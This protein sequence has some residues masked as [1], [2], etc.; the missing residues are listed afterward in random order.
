MTATNPTRTSTRTKS[1]FRCWCFPPTRLC[2]SAAKRTCDASASLTTFLKLS[3]LAVTLGFVFLLVFD[4]SEAASKDHPLRFKAGESTAYAEGRFSRRVREVYFSFYAH[5]GEHL[6]VKIT[7]ITPDL[8]TAGV[9]IYPSGTQD[10]GPG[11]TVFDSDLNET[12]KYRIR[13]THRQARING[14][15]RLSVTILN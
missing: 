8:I 15:F 10:G 11:G 13:V 5:D 6:V 7:P 14:R 1:F 9:V 2:E 4:S 12:G 3:V